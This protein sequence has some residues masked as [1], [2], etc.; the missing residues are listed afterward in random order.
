MIFLHQRNTKGTDEYNCTLPS[1][2]NFKCKTVK[3][4]YPRHNLHVNFQAMLCVVH[5]LNFSDLTSSSRFWLRDFSIS[6]ISVLRC[7]TLSSIIINYTRNHS[8]LN[9]QSCECI[10]D[11]YTGNYHKSRHCDIVPGPLEKKCS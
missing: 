9:S 7:L 3:S 11:H 8:F 6:V 5:R 10:Q 2:P 1:H 4:Y